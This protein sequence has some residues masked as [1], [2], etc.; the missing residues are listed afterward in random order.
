M[1]KRK[2]KDTFQEFQSNG[3]PSYK[4]IKTPLKSLLHNPY[5]VQPIIND[6]FLKIN[7]LVINSY[8]FI[9]LFTYTD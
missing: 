9:R 3:K 1:V 7:D 2:K 5:D 6:L 4:T 8:Q